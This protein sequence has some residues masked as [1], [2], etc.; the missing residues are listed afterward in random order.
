M[1]NA[2]FW[3]G[4]CDPGP[5]D[6]Y[7]EF[8]ICECGKSEEFCDGD[9][10]EYSLLQQTDPVTGEHPLSIYPE[11]EDPRIAQAEWDRDHGEDY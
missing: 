4:P 3:P 8:G 1:A 6:D 2:T 5:E 7:P 9:C 11:A 10:Y